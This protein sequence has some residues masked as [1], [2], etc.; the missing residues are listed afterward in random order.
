MSSEIKNYEIVLNTVYSGGAHAFLLN[1]SAVEPIMLVDVT[2]WKNVVKTSLVYQGYTEENSYQSLDDLF[3][4]LQPSAISINHLVWSTDM[5]GLI[6][7]IVLLCKH[8]RLIVYIHDFYTVCPTINLLDF[9]LEYCKVPD[10]NICFDCLSRYQDSLTA[11]TFAKSELARVGQIH[12]GN[13]NEWRGKWAL[14]FEQANQIIFPSK[15]S[16]KIWLRAFPDF[17]HKTNISP[18]NLDYLANISKQQPWLAED[19][20]NVFV[21]GEYIRELKGSQIIHGVLR[22]IKNNQL[23]IRI[24]ILGFYLDEEFENS[25]YLKQHGCFDH[26]NIDLVLNSKKIDCFLLPSIC[27]ETF[28]YAVHEMMSTGVPVIAFNLG[29]QGEFLADYKHGELIDT[30]NTDAMFDRLMIIYENYLKQRYPILSYQTDP[31]VAREVKALLKTISQLQVKVAEHDLM[32]LRAIAQAD[33][34][35]VELARHKTDRT[36]LQVSTINLDLISLYGSWSWK[37]TRLLRKFRNYFMALASK[38]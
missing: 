3:K 17:R 15:S 21:I 9:K 30:I 11:P 10:Q 24:N 2:D 33:H 35:R 32:R 34:D 23:N 1:K 20:F 22:K 13:I 37:L 38:Q 8:V 28:S 16:L 36:E 6:D 27:P 26:T 7:R 12:R 31:S 25:A 18:P 29:A 4:H 19:F 14:L 5:A